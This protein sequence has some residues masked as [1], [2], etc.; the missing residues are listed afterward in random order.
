[1]AFRILMRCLIRIG[2]KAYGKL[3]IGD[4]LNLIVSVKGLNHSLVQCERPIRF[5]TVVGLPWR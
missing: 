5:G 2:P 1:M 3:Q 4:C